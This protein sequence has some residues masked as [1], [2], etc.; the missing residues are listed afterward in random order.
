MM[1]SRIKWIKVKLLAFLK[2]VKLLLEFQRFATVLTDNIFHV[3]SV[4]P[5][6]MGIG[7]VLDPKGA[8]IFQ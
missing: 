2:E 3:C 8:V 6:D 7:K 4:C 1:T 5:L